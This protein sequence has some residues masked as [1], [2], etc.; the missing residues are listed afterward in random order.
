MTA[1]VG[2]QVNFSFTVFH[3]T[4]LGDGT[5]ISNVI[6]YDDY[7]GQATLVSGDDGNALLERNETWVYVA[8]YRVR[9]TD[10]T[11]LTNTAVVSG[12]NAAGNIVT[13]TAT[14]SMTIGYGF[15]SGFRKY[16]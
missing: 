16:Q 14:H 7:A 4:R 6:V 3:D 8:S 13:A 5:P 12:L 1:T 15:R 9:N 10:P 11:P 2:A